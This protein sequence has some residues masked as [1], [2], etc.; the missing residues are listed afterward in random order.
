MSDVAWCV[1]HGVPW[2]GDADFTCDR[3]DGACV[4]RDPDAPVESARNLLWCVIHDLEAAAI[5]DTHAICLVGASEQEPCRGVPGWLNLEVG[6]RRGV[7][8]E[9]A[10]IPRVVGSLSAERDFSNLESPLL[11]DFAYK[12]IDAI[13][14]TD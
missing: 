13:A 1:T 11:L 10:E 3:S 9:E 8:I 6:D 2:A 12:L 4:R 5:T 14:I 7:L